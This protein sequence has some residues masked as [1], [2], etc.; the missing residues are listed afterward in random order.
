[1]KAD[2]KINFGPL[3]ALGDITEV[4]EAI[5]GVLSDLLAD[6]E[7]ANEDGQRTIFLIGGSIDHG[8]T[9]LDDLDD[10]LRDAY[11]TSPDRPHAEWRAEIS[12]D[13]VVRYARTL[14]NSKDRPDTQI[15]GSS[16]LEIL[17]REETPHS[18][19][20]AR[21]GRRPAYSASV[22]GFVITV[23]PPSLELLFR[24]ALRRSGLNRLGVFDRKRILE[25]LKEREELKALTV[26]STT[27]ISAARLLKAAAAP[28][29]LSLHMKGAHAVDSEQ[30]EQLA[31]AFRIRLAYETSVVLAPIL[32]VDR[33]DESPSQP[34]LIRQL[35]HRA[36]EFVEAIGQGA[37]TG[38][39]GDQLL[40]RPVVTADELSLRY[41]RAVAARDPFSAFMGYYHVLEYHIEEAWFESLRKRVVTGGNALSRPPDDI[42]SAAKEAAKLLG[43]KHEEVKF[44]ELRALQALVEDRI[45]IRGFAVDLGTHLDG[46][47]EYFASGHLPFLEVD[48]LDFSQAQDSLRHAELC[49]K[50]AKRIYAVRCAITHSKASGDRYS[51]YTDDLYLGREV[52]L[53]RI[54]AEQLLIPGDDRL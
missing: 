14:V 10:A 46:A 32:D 18:I 42:R 37:P 25:I 38:A 24:C 43:V 19:L 35:H 13:S 15:I 44:T 41:L 31:T 6:H 28:H 49:Q 27:R 7:P 22:D 47:L 12:H 21:P 16:S 45:D 11:L 2:R 33:L 26:E 3:S 30:L 51:P 8:S 34:T 20:L 4:S 36:S 23:G 52:P 53:V 50:L 39:L 17:I 1:M 40:G 29:L 9:G 5:I 48:H 54:A